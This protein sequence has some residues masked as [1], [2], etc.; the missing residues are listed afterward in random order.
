LTYFNG[1]GLAEVSRYLFVLK[2]V[3]YE[4]YR[5]PDVPI[6][7]ETGMKRPLFEANKESYPF[8]QV[9]VL[10]V[11]GEKG[12]VLA[13]SKAI[14][15]YL[16]KEFGFMGCSAIEAQLIDSVGEAIRD[17]RD[18]YWK[19]REKPEE[20]TK[21]F[22]EVFPKAL[23]YLNRFAMEHGNKNHTF[24]GN[25]ISLADVQF[26]QALA[27]FNVYHDDEFSEKIIVGY[28]ALVAIRHNVATQPQIQKWIAERPV[29]FF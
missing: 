12:V 7:G 2:G 10:Q 24:V 20:K 6:P 15:R 14:E 16:A 13:Q 19:T 26:F 5:F 23:K 22:A 3:D 25:S 8:G 1:R 29:T 17:F 9:P 4:D 18:A 21:F 28:P 27:S 11:G